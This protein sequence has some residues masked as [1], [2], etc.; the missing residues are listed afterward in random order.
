MS[1]F[2]L[3]SHIAAPSA[4]RSS[5]AASCGSVP[6]RWEAASKSKA[7][8]V[9]VLLVDGIASSIPTSK[10]YRSSARAASGDSGSLVI[11]TSRLGAI[12]SSALRTS[13]DW[14]LCEI[15]TTVASRRPSIANAASVAASA[16]AR[17]PQRIIAIAPSSAA[18]SELP[19]PMKQISSASS[20]AARRTGKSVPAS[21]RHAPGC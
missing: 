10:L 18:I 3:P 9:E 19:L 1:A 16:V 14:P 8:V 17:M 21:L 20:A 2:S 6:I 7:C 11:A 5:A 13:P 4:A 12:M 15:A